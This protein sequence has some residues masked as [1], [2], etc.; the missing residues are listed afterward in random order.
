[1]SSLMGKQNDFSCHCVKSS[2]LTRF[3]CVCSQVPV[4]LQKVN[5]RLIGMSCPVN[6]QALPSGVLEA[7]FTPENMRRGGSALWDGSPAGEKLRLQLCAHR[8]PRL[9]LLEKALRLAQRHAHQGRVPSALLPGDVLV[10]CVFSTQEGA[11]DAVQ[12][13]AELHHCFKLSQLLKVRGH[14]VLTQQ[15]DCAAFVLSWS[16]VCPSVSVEVTPV[17]SVPIIPTALQRSLSSSSRPPQSS[18]PQRGFL[19]M[20]QTRKLLLLLEAPQFFQCRGSGSHLDYQLLRLSVCHSVPERPVCLS[21]IRTLESRT[22]TCPPVRP[23]ARTPPPSSSFS[24]NQNVRQAPGP[25]HRPPPD[26]K[27]APPPGNSSSSSAPPHLHSTPNS[28]L[29]Q[30]CSCC[31]SNNYNCTSIFSSPGLHPTP[32]SLHHHQ[33]PSSLHHHHQTPPPSTHLH[34]LSPAPIQLN[35]LLFLL[36]PLVSLPPPLHPPISKLL[37][38]PAIFSL[39]TLLLLL[40]TPTDCSDAA[41]GSG[42]TADPPQRGGGTEEHRQHRCGDR[43]QNVW[44]GLKRCKLKSKVQTL[45]LNGLEQ[46]ELDGCRNGQTGVKRFLKIVQTRV[47]CANRCGRT[48]VKKGVK[49][50]VDRCEDRCEERR[51]QVCRDVDRCVKKGV[52]R[53]VDRCEDRCEERRRQTGVERRRQVWRDVDRCEDVDRGQFVLGGSCLISL[54][55]SGGSSPPLPHLPPP[56][57]SSSSSSSSCKPPSHTYLSVSDHGVERSDITGQEAACSPASQHSLSGLQSRFWGRV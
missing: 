29:H 31:S 35:T 11:S 10:P 18:R 17:R 32:S 42:E 20:D 50:D 9:V 33:T 39:I 49:R 34:T 19:T 27:S 7:V 13:E 53:D 2:R 26:R 48:G 4:F 56:P 38:P 5:K 23:P 54:P 55:S 16:A 28:H 22:K 45:F 8:K 46:T 41:G 1:M 21:A 51:R 30:P 36:P 57:S 24:S 44:T 3:L 6:F 25:S 14:V 40:P 12:S 52:K 47:K 15:A 43:S 37:L